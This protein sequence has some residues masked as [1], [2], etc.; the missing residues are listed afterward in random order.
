MQ[1]QYSY[2]NK[3][4]L[5]MVLAGLCVS[6][7]VMAAT[8]PA[9]TSLATTQNLVRGNGA[10]PA[11]LDPD[12]VEDNSS[13]AIINDLFE[14]LVR[15]DDKGIVTPALADS[16]HTSDHKTWIFHIRPGVRWSDGS[17]ISAQD[18]VYSW[19][20][21]SAPQTASP[22]ASFT[23]NAHI[24]NAQAVIDGK[25]PPDQLGVSAPDSSTL[26]VVL[27]QPVSYFLQFVAH[28]SLFPVSEKDV[29]KYGDTWTQ[30]GHMVSSSAYQ[31]TDWVVNEKVTLKRNPR[32]WDNAHTV[33]N[34]VTFLPV[35]DSSAEL[36]R[37]L[38]GEIN[39]TSTIPAIDFSRMKKEKP[40]EVF[41]AP[42]LS[43]FYFDIN[44][45]RAPFN[46]ARVRQALN[47]ALNKDIISEKVLGMGQKAAWTVAPLS[48]GGVSI[49][50][51]AWAGWTPGQRIAKARELLKEAGYSAS[52]P[53]RFSVLYN[54]NADN[55]RIAIAA[56]SMWKSAL[57]VSVTL[58]NQ[59][60][61]SMLDTMHQGQFQLV[62]YT[63]G[64]DYN[65][66]STFL[67]TFR[68]GDSNNTGNYSNKAFDHEIA[69]AQLA[70]TPAETATDYQKA[71]EIA[72]NDAPAIPVFYGAQDY[73]VNRRV[74][75]FAPSL[76]GFYY[77]KDLY[78]KQ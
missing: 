34:Q 72:A 24:L 36:N 7:L 2:L 32:Y 41:A 63:W 8:V 68:S 54:N 70:Q 5:S 23:A 40:Q 51:P 28:P 56:A 29:E 9:G 38:A 13:M 1:G 55:Q 3:I 58:Q 78:L 76:L 62:R 73:M 57:G 66:Y 26:K 39:I 25:M 59:E 71:M 47:L 11:T 49:T 65:E 16:W 67:N 33:I 22:Y 10:E 61:K 75:G 15:V 45:G 64:A 19:R 6:P 30:P 37:Y 35:S 53:L 18:F 46:D 12:K 14:G 21:L 31:L 27:D 60:W 52:R 50:P 44:S 4:R 20:R 74:G 43:V 77:T 42:E 48:M 17:P 69:A